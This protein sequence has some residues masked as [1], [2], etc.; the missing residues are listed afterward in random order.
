MADETIYLSL[1]AYK[2]DSNNA[3]APPYSFKK[4][5]ITEPITLEPGEYDLDCFVNQGDKGEYLSIK[6][7]EPY[8]KPNF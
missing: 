6:V 3:K 2:N 8:K 5:K 4:F 1:I 7:K